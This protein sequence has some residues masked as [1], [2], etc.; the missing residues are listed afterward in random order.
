MKHRVVDFALYRS[1]L[2]KYDY[3]V[4]TIAGGDFTLPD[5]GTL[6][7]ILGSKSAAEEGN[8]NFRGVR[9]PAVDGLIAAIG[10]AETM[11]QLRD[12]ARALDRALAPA[13]I[14]FARH[15]LRPPY[16]IDGWRVDVIHMMGEGPGA[17]GN[18]ELIASFRAAVK[19]ERSDAYLLG[20]HF[21]EASRW[22]QGPHEDGAM[23]YFGFAQPL[24]AFLAGLDVAYH[25][26]RIDAAEFDQWLTAA[27][28]RIPYA[29]A[30]CQ[31]NL[32]DS[33]DTRRFLTMVN[34]DRQLLLLGLLLL[35]SYPG[36]PCLYYGTEVGLEGENDPDNR[37]CM[38]WDQG[39]QD[40][41]LLAH[42]RQ[43][44]SLR[45]QWPA[46]SHGGYLTLHAAGDLFIFARLL[47]ADGKQPQQQL[48]IA[49]NRGQQQ[50]EISGEHPLLAGR[51]W[52]RLWGEGQ[53]YD[54]Q[55]LLPPVSGSLW[56]LV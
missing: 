9:D 1:R 39:Q 31:L 32:L 30:L 20:E 46:L 13:L 29:N 52:Q 44:L 26:C 8:S 5:S 33:H 48:V 18:L 42:C 27:R 54:G 7:A 12:A 2:Q 16:A 51:Q 6:E 22:L 45:Q 28:A 37:R 50:G 47:E 3:D 10:R 40:Q 43:L 17:A 41:Q 55:L 56:L 36:V 11:Q 19:A 53:Q 35:I 34:G 14:A 49:I 15:Y 25:P 38:I 23:N 4:I 24:R 21:F